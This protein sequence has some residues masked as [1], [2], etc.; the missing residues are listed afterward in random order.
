MNERSTMASRLSRMESQLEERNTAINQFRATCEK[1]A[2]KISE[3]ER[4]WSEKSKQEGSTQKQELAT[5]TARINV[6]QKSELQL[7]QENANLLNSNQDLE[8]KLSETRYF[9]YEHV[10]MA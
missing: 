4:N 10:L 1:Q 8:N 5:M 2:S 7:K 6:L 3:M 9:F